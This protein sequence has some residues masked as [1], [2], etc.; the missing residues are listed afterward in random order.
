[1]SEGDVLA[2]LMRQAEVRGADLGTLRALAEE[3]S[4]RGAARAL[5]SLGLADA[6]ASGDIMQLRELLGAWREA[7][8]SALRAAVGWAVKLMLA[9]LLIGIAVRTGLG[10]TIK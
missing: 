10:E 6:G 1:M 7:K 4:E 9:L 3:A 8:K 2:H 5:A